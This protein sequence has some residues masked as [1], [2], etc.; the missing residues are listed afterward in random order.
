MASE[1][2]NNG[3]N[4]AKFVQNESGVQVNT[5]E[6]KVQNEETKTPAITE[7][8]SISL[9]FE[10][11]K[12][13]G[14]FMRTTN[15]DLSELIKAK[16]Q[17][18]FHELRGV[19]ITY[20]PTPNGRMDFFTEF[21]FE[22]NMDPLPEGKIE[23]ILDLSKPGAVTDSYFDSV[24]RVYSRSEG[25][26]FTLNNETRILLSDF[27]YG[28]R[29]ANKKNSKSWEQ[30]IDSIVL[31][32][33]ASYPGQAMYRNNAQ[34]VLIK[35]KNL[36]LKAILRALYGPT[37]V[38]ETGR[39]AKG[40]TVSYTAKAYYDVRYIKPLAANG[41]FSMNVEQFDPDEVARI[42]AMENPTMYVR[43][44]GLQFF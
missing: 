23:S 7:D 35:V 42:D 11:F 5:E 32:V 29:N 10:N 2:K 26:S 37:M 21:Y 3:N 44:M 6:A 17:G 4:E 22:K 14:N 25:K 33:G 38:V 24:K 41:I 30:N 8:S 40:E 16:F 13:F 12:S 31:N 34:E 15:K 18:I 39:N 43:P 19:M 27:M 9:T 28:G 1:N 20:Q 36:N